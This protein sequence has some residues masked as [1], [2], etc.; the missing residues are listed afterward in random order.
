MSDRAP[1]RAVAFGDAAVLL[2]VDQESGVVDDEAVEHLVRALAHEAAAL[3][4]ADPRFGAPVPGFSS[5]LVP[6]GTLDPG[7]DAA[8]PRL[9]D[10]AAAVAAGP[11][12]SAPSPSPAPLVR[13]PTRYGGEH[14]ADLDT[15]AELHG[16][17][18]ADVV[19]IHAS[20]EYRV[21]FLGFVPGFAYLG[22]VPAAIAT[23][24][25]PTPRDRVPA[26]SVAIA[27]EQTAVYPSVTPGGWRLIGRTE[28]RVWDPAAAAPSLLLPGTRVRFDPIR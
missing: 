27:G 1:V 15:V 28:L 6:V 17:R 8:M 25:L 23:P 9:E 12:R 18:P 13:I 26:G 14:G 2:V 10:L 19:E 20:T 21:R 11:E 3:H 4:A 22:R 24:R 7:V 5:V 16:L